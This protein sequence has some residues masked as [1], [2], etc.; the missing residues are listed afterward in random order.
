[1]SSES[2]SELSLTQFP[3]VAVLCLLHH[4][5]SLLSFGL[6]S[7]LAAV[8]ITAVLLVLV[9]VPALCV[10]ITVAFSAAAVKGTQAQGPSS[11][12]EHQT[13]IEV[14]NS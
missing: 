5:S 1:M 4:S 11:T 9:S 12:A 10:L 13:A 2:H 3:S 14:T 8:F 7:T 6:H